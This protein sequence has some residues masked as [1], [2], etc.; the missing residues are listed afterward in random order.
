MHNSHDEGDPDG[1]A[2]DRPVGTPR[3]RPVRICGKTQAIAAVLFSAAALSLQAG[4]CAE[5]GSSAARRP[6]ARR[7]PVLRESPH[8]TLHTDL[9]ADK[10]DSLLQR[11]EST[12]SFAADCWKRP[13]RG[14]IECYVAQDVQ[15]WPDYEL[16]NPAARVIIKG[17]GGVTFGQKSGAGKSR[18]NTAV[19]YA[20]AAPGVAEH[21]V[22]HAYCAQTFG[23]LGPTWYKEG[24]AEMAVLGHGELCS[25]RERLLTLRH[26]TARSIRDVLSAGEAAKQLT[27][28]LNSM[29]SNR[30]GNGQQVSIAAWTAR[31]TDS[32][33]LARQDCLRSWALCYLLYNNPNYSDRFQT[34]G[35]D[36]LTKRNVSFEQL[37]APMAREVSFEFEFFLQHVDTGYRVDLCRWDWH[38]R[39]TMQGGDDPR[40]HYTAARGWQASDISVS[41]GKR[42]SFDAAGQWSTSADRP[43]TDADG[44]AAGNGRLIAVVMQDFSLGDSFNLGTHGEFVAPQS[45]RLYLRCQDAWNELGDNCGQMRLQIQPVPNVP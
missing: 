28:S 39:Q 12:L 5:T 45:G 1:Y 15:N 17:I 21:E 22:I 20:S 3:R 4:R 35:S 19:I 9:P 24:M 36:Y 30:G 11:M 2:P 41:E 16:P 6:S 29:L 27:S 44:D 32:V 10:A 25:D 26:G 38:R 14:R 37:F 18:H 43:A 31:D 40:E 8:F 7:A 33:R 13:P 42:Y 34:L 23:E